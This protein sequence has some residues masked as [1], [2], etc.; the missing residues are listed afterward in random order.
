[1][2]D[3]IL[4]LLSGSKPPAATWTPLWAVLHNMAAF[5]HGTVALLKHASLL[6][7]VLQI[8]H[9]LAQRKQL[10]E[11]P[12]VL[13]ALG[14]IAAHTQG[15]RALL[16]TPAASGAP[17]AGTCTW[18]SCRSSAPS[19]WAHLETALNDSSHGCRF[20]GPTDILDASKTHA[21]QWSSNACVACPRT[22]ARRRHIL[23]G[24]PIGTALPRDLSWQSRCGQR[25]CCICCLGA[26]GFDV[27]LPEG[28]GFLCAIL[29]ASHGLGDC[30]SCV[31]KAPTTVKVE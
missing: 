19:L 30:C 29:S 11:L 12:P 31:L 5:S 27:Q 15:Q 4:A 26:L 20:A 21:D 3:R 9:Q 14:N 13:A 16:P 24:S 23:H 22:C 25:V 1:M 7:Q 2:L 18:C 6:P 28:N 8:A 17:H 10:S